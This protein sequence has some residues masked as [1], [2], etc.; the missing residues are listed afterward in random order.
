MKLQRDKVGQGRANMGTGDRAQR[1]RDV[2][3][4]DP[5]ALEFGQLANPLALEKSATFLEVRGHEID[6]SLRDQVPESVATV[7]VLA[8][9]DRAAPRLAN[10]ASC[11]ASSPASRGLRA[12]S[13]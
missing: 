8:G 13:G 1:R 10:V 12:R 2:V 3:R 6:G 4:S 11:R 7:E 9:E 5:D